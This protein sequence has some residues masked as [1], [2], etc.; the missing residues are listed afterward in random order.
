LKILSFN[1]YQYIKD[2]IKQTNETSER[3]NN[4]KARINAINSNIGQV[5]KKM[6]MMTVTNTPNPECIYI[7]ILFLKEMI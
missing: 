7:Y 2:L 3:I 6:G 1:I 5:E 4:I